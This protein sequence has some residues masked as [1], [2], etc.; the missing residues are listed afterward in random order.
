MCAPT[1]VNPR[2]LLE[3]FRQAGLLNPALSDSQALGLA[4]PVLKKLYAKDR[5]T[6]GGCGGSC[7]TSAK[8]VQV[9]RP[10]KAPSA[11]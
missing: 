6:G 5:A 11:V 9:V 7:S 10:E 2:I 4:Q 1:I 8:T 3:A